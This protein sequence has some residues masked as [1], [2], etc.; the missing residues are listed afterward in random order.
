MNTAVSTDGPGLNSVANAALKT[1]VRCW[2]LVAVMG[3][4][5]FVY[6]IAFYGGAA[7]QAPAF[8]Y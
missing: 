8:L 4:W 5:M 7:V 3:Q 1:T 6:Y 2:F